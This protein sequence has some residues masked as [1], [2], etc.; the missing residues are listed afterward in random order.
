MLPEWFIRI[1]RSFL[2]NKKKVASF[3]HDYVKVQDKQLPVGRKYKKEA[4]SKMDREAV[5]MSS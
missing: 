5:K 4:L 2:V 1:H 3:G